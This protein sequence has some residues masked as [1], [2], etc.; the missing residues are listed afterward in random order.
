[1]YFI[2]W[3][4]KTPNKLKDKRVKLL[5]QPERKPVEGSGNGTLGHA[6]HA[7][8]SRSS[9]SN[10]VRA[11]GDAALLESLPSLVPHLLH[12]GVPAPPEQ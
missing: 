11:V 8:G 4:K 1:M 10:A 6:F 2:S 7:L 3:G 9:A 5:Q 12:R